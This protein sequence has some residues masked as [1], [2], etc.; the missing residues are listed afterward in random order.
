MG[1]DTKEMREILS[2][3]G[4][5]Y[6]AV[7][8][9]EALDELDDLR[10]EVANAVTELAAEHVLHEATKMEL[11][12]EQQR[13]VAVC[14]A[15]EAT[16]QEYSSYRDAAESAYQT[17]ERLL[18]EAAAA[19]EATKRKLETEREAHG[20]A[21]RLNNELGSELEA[22]RA[23]LEEAEKALTSVDNTKFEYS[24]T[25]TRYDMVESIIKDY[26]ARYPKVK[27]GE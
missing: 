3:A 16:R 18:A 12:A 9:R 27:V 19:H 13:H 14:E 21:I 24:T 8:T 10:E 20:V 1:V 23:R 25:V 6:V 11:H 5:S 17:Q 2:I 26:F 15:H 4:T 22:L 7:C